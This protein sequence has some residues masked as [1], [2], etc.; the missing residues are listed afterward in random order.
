MFWSGFVKDVSA[1]TKMFIWD[2]TL[3]Q[4][5]NNISGK[6]LVGRFKK[7]YFRD[8][9]SIELVNLEECRPIERSDYAKMVRVSAVTQQDWLSFYRGKIE[10]LIED[11][12]IKKLIDLVFPSHDP[13]NHQPS[14][15]IFERW[16]VTLLQRKEHLK[17]PICV[18]H[19]PPDPILVHP[20]RS[21]SHP[22]PALVCQHQVDQLLY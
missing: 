5:L 8:S 14:A 16:V 21:R 3:V 19:Q 2:D 15:N 6:Y 4:A 12:S 17:Q 1:R 22:K 20:L 18:L 11:D 7:K 10:S 9:V 13:P